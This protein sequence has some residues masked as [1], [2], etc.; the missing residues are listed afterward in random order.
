[1][2]KNKLSSLLFL[3][4]LLPFL[5]VTS[6]RSAPQGTPSVPE[7]PNQKTGPLSFSASLPG[8]PGQWI[9]LGSLHLG[10]E[11]MY[12][13]PPPVE[14]GFKAADTLV[15]EA[16][17]GKEPDPGLLMA[18]IQ[19]PPGKNLS[20]LLPAPLKD[21]LNQFL[22]TLGLR[23]K[24][25][26]P[27]QPWYVEMN[28]ALRLLQGE[29]LQADLGIDR[30]FY[31][32]HAQEGKSLLALETMD[33]QL[34]LL[35]TDR[36]EDQALSLGETLKQAKEFRRYIQGLVDSWKTGDAVR[37]EEQYLSA[38]KASPALY[39]RLMVQRNQ[40]WARQ[41]TAWSGE[42]KKYFLVVGAAHLVG[43]ESLIRYLNEAGFQVQRL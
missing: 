10:T 17:L 15:L 37:L 6:C 12:P 30:H 8:K 33:R 29:G 32:R 3:I 39:H 14:Q 20:Q 18:R 43:Q 27:F 16:D 38:M 34:E 2:S 1:M 7:I 28:I 41:M 35:A 23:L 21:D 5:L 42:S 25:M 31:H 36:L 4:L 13:L 40:A 9:I 11:D 19:L 22:P 26:E 24:D